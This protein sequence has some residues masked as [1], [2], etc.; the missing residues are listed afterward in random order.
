MMGHRGNFQNNNTGSQGRSDGS[1]GPQMGGVA[2]ELTR[3]I[4][5]AEPNEQLFAET[6]EK[7]AKLLFSSGKGKRNKSTQIRRFYDELVL[8][9]ERV[10]ESPDVFTA[11]L[12]LIRMMKAKVAY[13]NGREL[14]SAE[15][16]D[17]MNHLI[18]QVKSPQTLSNARLFFEASLGFL[19]PL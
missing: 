12:P 6:A 16:V 11:N 4:Q 5:L 13:S 18:D 9:E 2:Q 14:V 15:F 19:K 3:A 7:F 17:V 10:C 8:W 1:R